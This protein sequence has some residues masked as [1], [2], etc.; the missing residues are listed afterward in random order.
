[1]GGEIA[2]RELKDAVAAHATCYEGSTKLLVMKAINAFYSPSYYDPQRR[3]I[4]KPLM[5]ITREALVQEI[6]SLA[7][8]ALLTN[9]SLILPNILIG[10]VD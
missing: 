2:R 10:N 4:T 6:K 7:Y 3:V 5:L 8:L 1:M 9:R